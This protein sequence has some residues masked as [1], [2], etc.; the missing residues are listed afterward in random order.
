[1][2]GKVTERA[3][4]CQIALSIVYRQLQNRLNGSGRPRKRRREIEDGRAGCASPGAAP[5]V[6]P[7]SLLYRY[8]HAESQIAP[9][10]C[11]TRRHPRHR[12]PPPA[13]PQPR[14]TGAQGDCRESR[15]GAE[16]G[17]AHRA[18]ASGGRVAAGRS[19]DQALPARRR[20]AAAGARRARELP[21]FRAWCGRSSTIS[22]A[23][24]ASWRSG[25]RCR[26]WTT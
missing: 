18:R 20:H 22:Q 12:H 4:N 24:T 7:Q 6:A 2:A 8:N 19:A 17:A 9:R 25:S 26:I 14:A 16:H 10:P 21:T 5:V 15:P 1:M 23:A 13:R 11:R 3:A